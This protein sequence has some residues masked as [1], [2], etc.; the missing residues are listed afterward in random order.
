MF[1]SLTVREAGI[2]KAAQCHA[3]AACLQTAPCQRASHHALFSAEIPAAA[4][5]TEIWPC[6]S[7]FLFSCPPIVNRAGWCAL[8]L[9]GMT[10]PDGSRGALGHRIVLLLPR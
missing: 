2:G 3:R 7:L 4:A 1:L 10:V 6:S 9:G 5:H 8:D